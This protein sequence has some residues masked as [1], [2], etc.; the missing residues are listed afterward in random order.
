MNS[1]S[2]SSQAARAAA[3]GSKPTSAAPADPGPGTIAADRDRL[4]EDLNRLRADFG[5]LKDSLARL[6]SQ[7]G[8]EA[9]KSVRNVQQSVASQVGSTASGIADAGSELASSAK[10]QAK[11]L[12][13]ELEGIARRNPLGTI[14]GALVIGVIIGMMSRGRD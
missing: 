13:S 5:S 10:A 9:A 11:T 3:V 8:G 14:A 4:T 6:L 2:P 1:T 7:V 12:A